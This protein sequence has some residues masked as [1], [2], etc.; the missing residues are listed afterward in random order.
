MKEIEFVLNF[1]GDTPA[2]LCSLV[3]NTVTF[4]KYS[5]GE[6]KYHHF[7]SFVMNDD[8]EIQHINTKEHIT[9]IFTKPLDDELFG[10]LRYNI[11][12]C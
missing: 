10:Y 1:Q 5:Q 3:K 9:D 6:I 12:G 4:N 7:R 2:G 8:V 11:N